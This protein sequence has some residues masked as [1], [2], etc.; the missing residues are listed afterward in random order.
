V[1]T[2]AVPPPRCF[3]LGYRATP[4]TLSVGAHALSMLSYPWQQLLPTW[5]LRFLGAQPGYFGRTL[6][7]DRV[8]EVYVRPGQEVVDVAFALAHEVGHAVDLEHLD[9]G[10]RA[11]WKATRGLPVS[12]AWFGESDEEDFATPAG[13][14]AECF[15][16]WQVG[17]AS[18]QSRL[19][20]APRDHEL[21]I[22]AELALGPLAATDPVGRVGPFPHFSTEGPAHA[23]R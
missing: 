12:Q 9:P 3:A 14:W 8:I 19:G 15:A 7:P 4:A 5:S 23:A 16:A 21:E 20:G 10:L 13:D 11:R 18:F 22:L 6:W 1:V 17:P 2:A